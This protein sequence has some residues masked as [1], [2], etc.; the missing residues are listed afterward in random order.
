[1]SKI[2]TVIIFLLGGVLGLGA[3]AC[4]SPQ[5]P[6]HDIAPSPRSDS[7]KAA[8]VDSASAKDPIAATPTKQ[9]AGAGESAVPVTMPTVPAIK[10]VLAL[11]PSMTDRKSVVVNQVRFL[12]MLSGDVGQF[13]RSLDEV[14][15]NWDFSSVPILLEIGRFLPVD[16]RSQIIGLLASKTGQQF[17]FDFDKWLQWSWKQNY[18]PHPQYAT[19]KS[20]LYRKIDP[21]FAEYFAHTSNAQIRL[22]EIRWGGVRRDGIPP[23]KNPEMIAANSA[24]YLSDSDVVFGIELNGDARAYPKRILAWHEMFKDTIGGESVNGVY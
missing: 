7:A 1:M 11:K 21:R 19:F 12:E 22:D 6:T 16:Q 3:M 24:T 14:R 23:L 5:V 15:H 8:T 20:A 2:Q 4:L 17:G 13:N 10:K 9:N 18:D